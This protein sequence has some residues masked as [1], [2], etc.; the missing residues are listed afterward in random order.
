MNSYERGE[1][2]ICSIVVETQTGVIVDPMTYM[3]ISINDPSGYLLVSNVSMSKDS[4]GN[5]HYDFNSTDNYPLGTYTVTYTA[6]DGVRVTKQ[7]DYF[8]LTE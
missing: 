7:L 2:V 3:Y 4:T 5:Y 8:N 6:K 1:T